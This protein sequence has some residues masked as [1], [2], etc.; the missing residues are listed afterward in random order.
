MMY[1]SIGSVKQHAPCFRLANSPAHFPFV[2]NNVAA[3]A[4]IYVGKYI[5]WSQQGRE[6]FH[7]SGRIRRMNHH[8][9]TICAVRYKSFYFICHSERCGEFRCSEP[10]LD[11]SLRSGWRLKQK[12]V[13]PTTLYIFA[14]NNLRNVHCFELAVTRLGCLGQLDQAAGATADDYGRA[15]FFNILL[16]FVKNFF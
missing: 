8:P 3:L 7:V 14:L 2:I 16:L 4:L 12:R 13:D 10:L 6:V 11:D 15:S 1:S 9:A 5:S